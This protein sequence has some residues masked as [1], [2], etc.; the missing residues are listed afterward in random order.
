L[1]LEEHITNVIQYGFGDSGLHEI[2]VSLALDQDC[3]VV[4]VKDDGKAFD[5]LKNPEVNTSVPLEKRPVG[6]LGIHLMRRFMDELKYRRTSGQNVL[7][8]RKRLPGAPA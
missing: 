7:T 6:G 2:V 8:M 3:L 5:P 4:E 1:C